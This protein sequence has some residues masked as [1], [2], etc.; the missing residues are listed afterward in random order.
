MIYGLKPLWLFLSRKGAA[1]AIDL[2]SQLEQAGVDSRNN[3]TQRREKTRLLNADYDTSLDDIE[4]HFDQI[5]LD[6]KANQKRISVIHR[7]LVSA[8]TTDEWA[9]LEKVHSKAMDAVT[10][11]LQ[12]I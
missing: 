12:S 6:M 1:I 11:S 7:Q 2:I 10:K 3:I 5:K 9:E 4:S 8:T